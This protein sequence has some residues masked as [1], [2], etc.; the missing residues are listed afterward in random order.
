MGPIGGAP[1]VKECE[2]VTPAVV[3]ASGQGFVRCTPNAAKLR[4]V[5]DIGPLDFRRQCR[6]DVCRAGQLPAGGGVAFAG[7]GHTR[8]NAT[9]EGLVHSHL[10]VPLQGDRCSTLHRDRRKGP[11]TMLPRTGRPLC[12]DQADGVDVGTG[13]RAGG[14]AASTV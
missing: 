8:P 3:R 10:S 7:L 2:P 9:L 4:G 6:I 12:P 13:L 11:V 14:A 1:G 5:R